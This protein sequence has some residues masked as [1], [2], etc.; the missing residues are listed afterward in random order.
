[1]LDLFFGDQ[2]EGIRKNIL[3]DMMGWMGVKM[4]KKGFP[5]YIFS[6]LIISPKMCKIDH[7]I[8]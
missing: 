5:F 1:M 6:T 8:E 3:E 7:V 4:E 2:P